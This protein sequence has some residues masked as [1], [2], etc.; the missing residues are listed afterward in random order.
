M[1]EAV[2]LT[3]A[4]DGRGAGDEDATPGGFGLNSLEERVEALGGTASWGGRPEGGFVLE[5]GLPIGPEVGP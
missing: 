4:D 2:R 5:V 3:V 1:K